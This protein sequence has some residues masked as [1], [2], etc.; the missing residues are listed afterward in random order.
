M[1]GLTLPT[2]VL[3]YTTKTIDAV[4]SQAALEGNEVEVD[5]YERSDVSKKHVASGKRMKG[6]GDMFRVSVTTGAGSHSDDWSYTIL[7]ESA[8]R[9][10]KMKK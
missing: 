3:E 2:Y 8:G 4:L 1:A 10:R 5:V 7:R 9:S 6:D